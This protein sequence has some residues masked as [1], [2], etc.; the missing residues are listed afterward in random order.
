MYRSELQPLESSKNAGCKGDRVAFENVLKNSEM[1]QLVKVFLLAL[2]K[3]NDS[4]LKSAS[5]LFQFEKFRRSRVSPFDSVLLP[6]RLGTDYPVC[7]AC[8]IA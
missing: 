7:G 1:V 8:G 2:Q 5:V 6:P 4:N 3:S